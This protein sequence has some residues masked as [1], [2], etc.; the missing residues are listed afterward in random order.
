MWLLVLGVFFECV[1]RDGGFFVES[2]HVMLLLPDFCA[3]GVSE[4][5]LHELYYNLIVIYYDS[6]WA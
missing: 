1:G 5:A 6:W 4:Y 2:T 3:E